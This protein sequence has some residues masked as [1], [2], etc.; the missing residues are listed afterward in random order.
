MRINEWVITILNSIFR[1]WRKWSQNAFAKVWPESVNRK[2]SA[3]VVKWKQCLGL[4]ETSGRSLGNERSSASWSDW[5]ILMNIF[6]SYVRTS[7]HKASV[8]FCDFE[9][10]RISSKREKASAN[11]KSGAG[12]L[13]NFAGEMLN[14]T[15]VPQIPWRLYVWPLFKPQVMALWSVRPVSCPFS[16][17]WWKCTGVMRKFQILQL[18]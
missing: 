1:V 2:A 9:C 12:K 14:A 16:K 10:L 11:I 5:R 18:G 15:W 7:G 6:H 4:F 8:Y 17:I 3:K 13:S